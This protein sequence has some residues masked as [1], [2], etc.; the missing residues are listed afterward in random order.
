MFHL[1]FVFLAKVHAGIFLDAKPFNILNLVA[2]IY[3]DRKSKLRWIA[4]VAPHHY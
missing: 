1:N 2:A 4:Y 3:Q